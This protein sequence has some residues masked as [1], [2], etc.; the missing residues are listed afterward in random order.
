MIKFYLINFTQIYH[1]LLMLTTLIYCVSNSA[2]ILLTV[3]TTLIFSTCFK[4]CFLL[5]LFTL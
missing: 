4:K 5:Y 3:E 1:Q 2:Y